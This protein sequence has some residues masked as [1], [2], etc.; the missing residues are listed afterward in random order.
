MSQY[1]LTLL[2]IKIAVPEAIATKAAGVANNLKIISV[3]AK[4]RFCSATFFCEAVL[5]I[6]AGK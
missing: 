6:S 5:T 3:I 4:L 1:S 2:V